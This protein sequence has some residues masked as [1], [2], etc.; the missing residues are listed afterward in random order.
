[1]LLGISSITSSPANVAMPQLSIHAYFV[2]VG[3]IGIT[4]LK[5]IQLFATHDVDDMR[6]QFA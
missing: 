5:V 6:N 1:M 4:N 2:C 3:F